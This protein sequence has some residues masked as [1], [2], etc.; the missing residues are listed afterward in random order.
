MDRALAELNIV[1]KK[2]LEAHRRREVKAGKNQKL[3]SHA[4]LDLLYIKTVNY[5]SEL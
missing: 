5:N 3:Q 1:G 4:T 2:S